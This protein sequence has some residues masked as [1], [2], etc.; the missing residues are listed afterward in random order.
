MVTA[1]IR[2]TIGRPPLVRSAAACRERAE[3]RRVGVPAGSHRCVAG[4]ELACALGDNLDH[5]G[6]W[7]LVIPLPRHPSRAPA[8]PFNG[9]QRWDGSTTASGRKNRPPPCCGRGAPVVRW[10]TESDSAASDV[11]PARFDLRIIRAMQSS[12]RPRHD[13]WVRG[14]ALLP[15][16]SG[17]HAKRRGWD[18]AANDAPRTKRKR[19]DRGPLTLQGRRCILRKHPARCPLRVD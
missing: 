8:T 3:R 11:D 15:T 6:R 1:G 10:P 4:A 18:H 7:R 16:G 5:A 19:G 2:P 17:Q 12:G 13:G 14:K 9:E